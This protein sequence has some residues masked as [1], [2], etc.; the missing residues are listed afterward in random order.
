MVT[1]AHKIKQAL[2]SLFARSNRGMCVDLGAMHVVMAKLSINLSS[3]LRWIQSGNLTALKHIVLGTTGMST[4]TQ[5]YCKDLFDPSLPN[6]TIAVLAFGVTPLVKPLSMKLESETR[7]G[8]HA[9]SYRLPIPIQN[10]V[11]MNQQ[12]D[13]CRQEKL[14]YDYEEMRTFTRLLAATSQKHKK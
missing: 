14:V 2:Q 11:N 12:R 3:I 1:P 7:Q 8:L 13:C 10:V 6:D 4:S 5:I 9:L